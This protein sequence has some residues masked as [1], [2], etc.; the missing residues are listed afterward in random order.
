MAATAAFKTR[1]VV[2]AT[3][4]EHVRALC[5]QGHLK[6]A[7][8]IFQITENPV[9]SSTYIYLL[10]DC[11]KNKALTEG[12]LIHAHIN[13]Y[14]NVRCFTDKAVLSNTLMN[15]YVK[16]GSIVDA[17][18]VFGQMPQ[19]NVC[20][21]TVMIAAYSSHGF[22]EEALS[23]FGEM[24]HAHLKPNEF[25]FA[26]VLPACAKLASLQLGMQMHREIISSGFQS[27]LVVANALVD[28]YAKCGRIETA[29]KMFDKISEP[30][31]IS[32]TIM[33]AGYSKAGNLKES[34]K[35][36]QKIPH[37]DICA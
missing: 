32:W 16:C 22:A 23:L 21:W 30:D 19:R 6:E 7:L 2:N 29:R 26:S 13:I 14:E 34:Q 15:M 25:T 9:Q 28:M 1:E 3:S 11:I 20:S 36:F 5:K 33:I 18:K 4:M 27:D 8:H 35:L 12:K 17:R 10:Q 24:Q 37:S 31:V